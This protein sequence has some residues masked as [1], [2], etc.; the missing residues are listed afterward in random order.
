MKI[1]ISNNTDVQSIDKIDSQ[2]DKLKKT[3]QEI[4]FDDEDVARSILLEKYPNY[5]LHIGECG[6]TEIFDEKGQRIVKTEYTKG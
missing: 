5:I 6:T 3:L 4:M 1:T 2:E